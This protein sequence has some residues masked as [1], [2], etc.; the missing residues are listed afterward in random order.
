MHR[1]HR[2]SLPYPPSVVIVGGIPSCERFGGMQLVCASYVPTLKL[3]L[4]AQVLSSHGGRLLLFHGWVC[5]ERDPSACRWYS[6][7]TYGDSAQEYPG[8]LLLQRRLARRQPQWSTTSGGL[9]NTEQAKHL[10]ETDGTPACTPMCCHLWSPADRNCISLPAL[11]S[12]WDS[13]HIGA[14][15]RTAAR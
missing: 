7:C 2:W 4:H 11:H 9:K 12:A 5:G 1:A 15:N 3:H 6:G 13:Q 10:V 14:S 8:L